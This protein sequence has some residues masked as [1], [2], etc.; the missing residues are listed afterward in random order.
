[1]ETAEAKFRKLGEP[2][3]KTSKF[4]PVICSIRVSRNEIKT[5]IADSLHIV[6]DLAF[7][8]A[9]MQG[10][11][12]IYCRSNTVDIARQENLY[13]LNESYETSDSKYIC[14]RTDKWF[15]M[16]QKA[17]VTGST[18][19]A[20]AGLGKLKEEQQQHINNVNKDNAA[21]PKITIDK[22]PRKKWSL[23][24]PMKLMPSPH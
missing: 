4:Y 19:N 16:R 1:M 18:C 21:R 24:V 23:G 6:D 20:A 15:E 3:W 5:Q 22:K 7:F 9:T 13:R 12:M 10:Y 17:K 14:Q 8:G 2:D 11:Q